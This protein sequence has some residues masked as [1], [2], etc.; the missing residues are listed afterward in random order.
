MMDILLHSFFQQDDLI[1]TSRFRKITQE[2]FEALFAEDV[3]LYSLN[4][5]LWNTNL[6]FCGHTFCQGYKSVTG[7]FQ[8]LPLSVFKRIV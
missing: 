2:L 3:T 5:N 4:E 6:V 1:R 8:P 7:L